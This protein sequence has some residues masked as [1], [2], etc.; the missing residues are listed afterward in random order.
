[1]HWSW[2][3]SGGGGGENL[4]RLFDAEIGFDEVVLRKF[5]FSFDLKNPHPKSL[6]QRERDFV[7]KSLPPGEQVRSLP[8]SLVGRRGRGMRV[9]DE[10][11]QLF[12]L[13]I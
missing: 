4:I 8:F 2:T 13:L 7:E 9:M 12:A 5:V 3:G 1:M 10:N 11:T 6:S